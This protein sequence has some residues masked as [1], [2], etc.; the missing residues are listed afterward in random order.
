MDGRIGGCMPKIKNCLASLRSQIQAQGK[1]LTLNSSLPGAFAVLFA[2]TNFV[3]NLNSAHYVKRS[4]QEK[5]R[6]EEARENHDG[7]EG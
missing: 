7:K 4:R 3:Q 6:E 5:G 2:F 1:V